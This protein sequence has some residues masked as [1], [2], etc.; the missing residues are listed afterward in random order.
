M[1]HVKHCLDKLKGGMSVSQ[2]WLV[3]IIQYSGSVAPILRGKMQQKK[4]KA[5]NL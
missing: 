3:Y 4:K 2:G 5:C 1:F